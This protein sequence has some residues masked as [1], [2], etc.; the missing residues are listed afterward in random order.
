MDINKYINKYNRN[1]EL[2]LRTRQIKAPKDH[3]NY[4]NGINTKKHTDMPPLGSMYE[5]FKQT[6]NTDTHDTNEGE[7]LNKID[8]DDNDYILNSEITMMK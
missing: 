8:L 4:L 5:Y 7:I 2:K 1:M 6:S 3:W